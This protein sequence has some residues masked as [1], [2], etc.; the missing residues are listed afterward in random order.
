MLCVGNKSD[1]NVSLLDESSSDEDDSPAVVVSSVEAVKELDQKV[2]SPN[3]LMTLATASTE[4]TR[5]TA[6][7][8]KEA[9]VGLGT[10]SVV[11]QRKR[12]RFSEH[13]YY[14]AFKIFALFLIWLEILNFLKL[15]ISWV[16]YSKKFH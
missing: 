12:R 16:I 9:S 8:P 6:E 13:D 2:E 10:G 1:L 11:Q 14:V 15:F 3:R 7:R 5:N 4:I